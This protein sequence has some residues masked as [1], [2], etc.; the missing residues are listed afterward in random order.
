MN[1]QLA[2]IRLGKIV[3]TSLLIIIVVF[4]I[5][6]AVVAVYAFI[7]GAEARGSPDP[8]QIQLF[9]RR[10]GSIWGPIVGTVAT[11]SGAVWMTRRLPNT[12]LV[13]GA[14]VG[15]IIALVGLIAGKFSLRS[16][17]ISLAIFLAGFTGGIFSA[18][19]QKHRSASKQET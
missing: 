13:H 14:L 19:Y 6:A 9:A 2:D 10:I 5:I 12:Q 17:L 16:I 3:L 18:W 15:A 8:Q 7:L 1:I 4:V 11:L